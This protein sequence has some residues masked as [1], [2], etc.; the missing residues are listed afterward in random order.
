MPAEFE[1][2]AALLIVCDPI[3]GLYPLMAAVSLLLPYTKSNEPLP[4]HL[5]QRLTG[6]LEN[7][8]AQSQVLEHEKERVVEAI[9]DRRAT[10]DALEKE[11]ARLSRVRDRVDEAKKALGI[12]RQAYATSIGVIRHI[13]PGSFNSQS[14]MR[15]VRLTIQVV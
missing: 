6:F 2:N 15:M 1:A 12:K 14:R 8:D 11:I 13:P 5:H 4:D 9:A 7:L 10:I 3:S